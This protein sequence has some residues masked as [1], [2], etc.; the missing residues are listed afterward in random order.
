MPEASHSSPSLERM[1]SVRVRAVSRRSP[2]QLA[3][4]R[5][6]RFWSTTGQRSACMAAVT[7]PQ[8]ALPPPPPEKDPSTPP[9]RAAFA[10]SSNNPTSQSGPAA[11]ASA[12]AELTS[13]AASPIAGPPRT[14]RLSLTFWRPAPK[15]VAP[16]N[17][18]SSSP[19]ST[20]VGHQAR[21]LFALLSGQTPP[22]RSDRL[23]RPSHA[24]LSAPTLSE[25]AVSC[26][27]AKP[28]AP[29]VHVAKIKG[30]K[31]AQHQQKAMKK[32]KHQL[33]KPVSGPSR[34]R[35]F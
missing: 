28:A 3:L 10:L 8:A 25:A 18:A 27:G 9:A 26:D 7:A 2:S 13:T 35:F 1:R 5:S 4:L 19:T 12:V 21:V 24:V 14:K 33:Q 29:H 23:V 16:L 30:K 11:A 17:N 20:P 22:S 32:L 6:R 34:A 31:A 15:D